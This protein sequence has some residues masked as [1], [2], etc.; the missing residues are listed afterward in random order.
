MGLT[1]QNNF[2]KIS[3]SNKN[4]AIQELVDLIHGFSHIEFQKNLIPFR[5][6]R[7]GHEIIVN[8]QNFTIKRNSDFNISF[9]WTAEGFFI[10]AY[11][12]LMKDMIKFRASVRPFDNDTV[13]DAIEYP[14]LQ[15]LTSCGDSTYL[16]HS[17]ATGVLMRNPVQM[18]PGDGTLRFAPYPECFS[19]ASMQMMSFYHLDKAGLYLAAHDANGAQKW[20]N[21]YTTID[22]GSRFLSLSHIYGMENIGAGKDVS[23][24]YDFVIRITSGKSWE[25]AADLYRDFALKQTWCSR[26]RLDQKREKNDWLHKKVGY[27]TFGINAAYDRSLWL[28][29]YQEDIGTHGFHVLGPDWTNKPQT[30]D[31]GVPGGIEDWLPSHLSERNISKIRNNGDYFA[32]FEFDFLVN[33][34][35]HQQEELKKCLMKFPKEPMSHDAYKFSMMCPCETFTAKFHRERDCELAL[36]SDMDAIYYDISANNLIKTCLR[37]DH[38]HNKGGGREITQ[39]YKTIFGETKQSMLKA[40]KRPVLIGTEQI[41][42]VFLDKIDFYQAR[43]WAQPCSTLETWPIRTQILS[44]QAEIIPLFD[45]I[46]HEFGVVRMDG[47]GKLVEETGNLFYDIVAKVYLW[48]GLYEIN[49]EYSSMEEINGIVNSSQE[50]YYKFC[51]RRYRYSKLRAQWI[52]QFAMARIKLANEYWCYGKMIK[53]PSVSEKKYTYDWYHYN[54]GKND[55]AYQ[56]HGKITVPAVRVSAFKS[57]N[58]SIAIFMAVPGDEEQEI[59]LPIK[60]IST[61]NRSKIAVLYE[62]ISGEAKIIKDFG[63]ISKDGIIN[64]KIKLNPK[65]L[66]MLEIK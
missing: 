53:A 63:I 20:L 43:S 54:C 5:L 12:S 62:I 35:Q 34:K 51:T 48:G 11:V 21:A 14:I 55:A 19:G 6:F 8:L 22:N 17:W 50:H 52:R 7:N 18:L 26:G 56:Q 45:Y 47:W 44:G 2:I 37:E 58:N 41:S 25:E 38:N 49:H 30:F 60:D 40:T 9:Y 15:G 3:F 36:E 1:L 4:G 16:A 46:Y 61:E 66:Y 13:V 10:K 33:L 32:L 29:K 64:R 31:N 27:C 24:D 59:F 57:Q 23:M 39:G 42:E 65:S 28:Q